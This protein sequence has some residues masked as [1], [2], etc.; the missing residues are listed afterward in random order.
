MKLKML[1]AQAILTLPDGTEKQVSKLGRGRYTTA[2]QNCTSV[3]LQTHEKD[4]GKEI[5]C[6]LQNLRATSYSRLQTF[7][8]AGDSIY[9]WYQMPLY[10]PLT[11]KAGKAWEDFKL[12]KS[13]IE[14]A[15]RS[16]RIRKNGQMTKTPIG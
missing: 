16:Y 12:L 1:P 7:G 13:L 9:N 3:Y 15:R 10:R 11:A 4:S 8:I 5:A 14:D 2:W 6:R